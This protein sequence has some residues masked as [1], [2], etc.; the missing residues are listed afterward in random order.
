MKIK[1]PLINQFYEEDTKEPKEHKDQP[2][3]RP[4]F[5][6]I[7]PLEQAKYELDNPDMVKEVIIQT[8]PSDEFLKY[9]ARTE[10]D[11]KAKLEAAISAIEA[12]KLDQ[13]VQPVDFQTEPALPKSA[14]RADEMPQP[15]KVEKKV[16]ILDPQLDQ[17]DFGIT[18]RK[19]TL[20]QRFEFFKMY[21]ERRQEI[22]E[23]SMLWKNPSLPFNIISVIFV[24]SLLFIGGVFEFD[25]IPLKIP[26]FY[27]HVEKSWEQ[28]DKSTV[29]IMGTILLVTEGILINLI[30]K[31]F[32]S[33]RRLALTLSWVITFINVLMIIA[34]LQIYS[35]IT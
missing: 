23:I 19:L 11:T 29:F 22:L 4:S 30:I 5:A 32:K 31:I 16:K 20:S 28:T 26:L 6:Y 25:K 2:L 33:D 10:A 21:F 14:V 7:K 8:K 27:N 18:P 1:R 17:L 15:L 24:I 9:K 35:L 3:E 13:L 12:E 34:A